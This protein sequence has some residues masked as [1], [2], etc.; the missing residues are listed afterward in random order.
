MD[1]EQMDAPVGRGREPVGDACRRRCGAERRS[2]HHDAVAEL[3]CLDAIGC[4]H[5]HVRGPGS[6][7]PCRPGDV[8]VVV[9][10][11]HEHG[12]LDPLELARQERDGVGGDRCVLVDVAGEHDGADSL[13]PSGGERPRE[14]ARRETRPAATG[15]ATIVSGAEHG[16]RGGCLR[17][18]GSSWAWTPQCRVGSGWSRF[19]ERRFTELRPLVTPVEHCGAYRRGM[20]S[21]RGFGVA[22]VGVSLCVAG[23]VWAL[24]GGGAAPFSSGTV[25]RVVDGDTIFVRGPGGRTEDVR[26]IGIDTPETVDPRARWRSVRGLRVRQAP[27]DRAPGAA[28]LRP[29]AA[30]PL[31]PLP[32]L[33][34]AVSVAPA[35]RERESFA[36]AMRARY[37]FPP[38]TAHAGLFAVLQ[39]SAALGGRGL[40]SSCS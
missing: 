20:R 39:R 12:H 5:V 18:G 7:L 4:E 34:V 6:E 21:V 24:T 26:L 32:G 13:G 31:R 15:V 37:S 1:R 22:V 25:V 36:A 9:A 17:R 23:A 38:N 3:E 27:A 40:W 16:G 11:R 19:R 33:R 28:H 14:V 29:R 10:G 8:G 30:R 35:V 2:P